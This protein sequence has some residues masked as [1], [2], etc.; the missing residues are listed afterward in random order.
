MNR[1]HF[2]F[3]VINELRG[4]AS[5]DLNVEWVKKNMILGKVFIYN[6]GTHLFHSSCIRVQNYCTYIT[7][8]TN[9]YFK[10]A[11]MCN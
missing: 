7:F 10:S 11:A 3:Y 2:V 8:A 6:H 4:C 1:V 5:T 9:N